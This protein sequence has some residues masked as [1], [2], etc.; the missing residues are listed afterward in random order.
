MTALLALVRV[1]DP[2]LQPRV[3]AALNQLDWESLEDSQRLDLLRI[4]S[5]AF[6]R[7]G[8]PVETMCAKL[9]AK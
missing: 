6:L 5:L 3:V 9:I 8:S 7:M 4:Y 2:S 1:G